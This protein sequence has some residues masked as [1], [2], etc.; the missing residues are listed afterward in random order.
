MTTQ[1][2][3]DLR[4]Q[5]LHALDT[6]DRLVTN[7]GEE[8]LPR[9][10]PC[11]DFDVRDLAD[12]LV[13]VV[14]RLRIMLGGGAFTD[15]V[16]SGAESVTHLHAA[17]DEGRDALREALPGFDLGLEVTAPF[18]TMPAAV[19]I[20]SYVTELSVHGWDLAT[21]LARRDLLDDAFA[22]PLVERT[23]QWIPRE[24]REHIP[25]GEVVDVPDDAPAYDRLVGWMGRDPHWRA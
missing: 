8:D 15:A 9:P 11:S 20:G 6:T 16:P 5:L 19:V 18:G 23:Q 24:G 17:W 7:I 25:F 21:A 3:P 22:A 13:M 12:H 10:T 4:P 1:T 14:R 2:L